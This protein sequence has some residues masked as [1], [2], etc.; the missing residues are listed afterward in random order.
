MIEQA[1]KHRRPS[2]FTVGDVVWVKSKEFLPEE[3][4]SQKL[5][6]AYRGP[7]QILGVIG[8]V[9]GPSYV[10]EI[11]PHLHTYPVFHALLPCVSNELFPSRRSVVPPD[12]DGNYDVDRIVAVDVYRSGRRGGPQRQYKVIFAYQEPLEDCWLTRNELVE[13]ALHIAPDNDGST[14]ASR[15]YK[16]PTFR[17]EKFD[18]YTHQ[19]P[20]IWWQG[21]TAETGIHEVPNHLYISMLFLNAKGGCQIW[22]SH[23]ATIH[24]VQVSDLHKKI[25]WN[26]MARE[27]KKRFIVDDAQ[28][29]ASSRLFSMTQG[30]TPTRDWLTE[31]QKIVATP[32]LDLPFSHLRREFYNRSCAALSHALVPAPLMDVRVEVVDLHD[33]VAK[34]DREFKTQRGLIWISLELPALHSEILPL[35]KSLQPSGRLGL[36]LS[37]YDLI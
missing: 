36:L 16:M 5:L 1:N 21:F 28:A 20:V 7:W 6:P 37:V 23:M 27:W 17:I 34:I 31:W 10:V 3:N 35:D 12:M 30:N 15:P 9:D 4:I 29:L 18:D 19:D 25:S 11:P 2:Q 14:S 22:L 33:Y 13:T 8:D 26:E 24:D 32:D